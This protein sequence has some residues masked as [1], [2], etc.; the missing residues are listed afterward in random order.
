MDMSL[1]EEKKMVMCEVEGGGELLLTGEC[2]PFREDTIV[3][4][5]TCILNLCALQSW[6]IGARCTFSPPLVVSIHAPN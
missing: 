5:L 4:T 1:D 2:N 3:C 6:C